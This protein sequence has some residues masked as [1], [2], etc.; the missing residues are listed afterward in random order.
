[1]KHKEVEYVLTPE[2]AAQ[3]DAHVKK[4]R[5]NSLSTKPMDQ[6]EQALVTKLMG[7][8]YTVNGFQ[9]PRVVFVPSPFAMQY[10]AAFA[11]ALLDAGVKKFVYTPKSHFGAVV[12]NAII[13]AAALEMPLVEVPPIKE[14]SH[15]KHPFSGIDFYDLRD[16]MKTMGVPMETLLQQ[17]FSVYNEA[18]QGGNQ[19]SG[20]ISYVSFFQDVGKCGEAPYGPE[21]KGVD[22]TKWNIWKELGIHSGTRCVYEEF[23]IVSDRHEVFNLNDFGQPHNETGPFRAWRDGVKHYAV[24]GAYVPAYAVEHPDT[25][26]LETIENEKDGDIRSGLIT[27]YGTTKWLIATG[28]E[29]IDEDYVPAGGG[30]P[31]MIMRVLCR[32]TDTN[33][34]VVQFVLTHDGSTPKLYAIA[35][36]AS[37]KTCAE[38]I[39]STFGVPDSQ[40]IAQG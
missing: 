5:E 6:E 20:E 11:R 9:E 15:C 14:D 38:A 40:I 29:P 34:D 25:I 19:W 39:E 26:S 28:A 13:Q 27:L 33:G 31:H 4:W 18:W 36:T 30:R 23:A 17:A 1:V 24:A 12:M 2:H 10:A 16:M 22:Y 7:Q 8:L 37:A 3:V 21:G 35:A 32:K